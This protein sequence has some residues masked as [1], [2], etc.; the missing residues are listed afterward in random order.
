M[1]DS[2]LAMSVHGKV[3]EPVLQ[4]GLAIQFSNYQNGQSLVAMTRVKMVTD[5]FA[6][7]SKRLR[8]Y[9]LGTIDIGLGKLCT[10][11]HQ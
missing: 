10:N 9:S 6:N 4:G 3:G 5:D 11:L 2:G 1:D 8:K 7:E